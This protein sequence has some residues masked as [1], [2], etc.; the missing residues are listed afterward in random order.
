MTDTTRYI[1]VVERLYRDFED[2]HSLSTILD[3]VRECQAQLDGQVPAESHPELL[4]RLARQRLT[5][6]VRH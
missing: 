2:R 5:A 1:D 3:V 4:E 6:A